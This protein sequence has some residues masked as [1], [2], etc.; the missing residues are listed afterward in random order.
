[1]EATAGITKTAPAVSEGIYD[2]GTADNIHGN[3]EVEA[4]TANSGGGGGSETCENEYDPDE[5]NLYEAV[6]EKAK[7]GV[8]EKATA[9]AKA[10]AEKADAAD[11]ARIAEKKAAEE[12]EAAEVARI[13]AEEAEERRVAEEADKKIR[14]IFRSGPLANKPPALTPEEQEKMFADYRVEMLQ[15]T[16]LVLGDNAEAR[17]EKI[18]DQMDR[19]GKTTT[20]RPWIPF[21]SAEYSAHSKYCNKLDGKDIGHGHDL[22][23]GDW[24]CNNGGH[25]VEWHLL[26]EFFGT[27][28]AG[29][30]KLLDKSVTLGETDLNEWLDV[31]V[32][33]AIQLD[34]EKNLEKL[35]GGR[36]ED[37]KLFNVD[38]GE[39]FIEQTL[40]D[41]LILKVAVKATIN[42][43]DSTRDGQKAPF[44]ITPPSPATETFDFEPVVK[45]NRCNGRVWRKNPVAATIKSLSNSGYMGCQLKLVGVTPCDV[46]WV[47][48][49]PTSLFDKFLLHLDYCLDLVVDWINTG[50]SGKSPFVSQLDAVEERLDK[51]KE[52]SS[53]DEQNTF[54]LYYYIRRLR[55]LIGGGT[56]MSHAKYIAAGKRIYKAGANFR[57]GTVSKVKFTTTKMDG[58][59]G[60]TVAMDVDM[61]QTVGPPV[62]HSHIWP[63][64]DMA[65]PLNES[66]L[67]ELRTSLIKTA[68]AVYDK[69]E[70]SSFRL[71][72]IDGS[73]EPHKLLPLDKSN[74]EAVIN[75]HI[76]AGGIHIDQAEIDARLKRAGAASG[77]ITVSRWPGRPDPTWTSRFSPQTTSL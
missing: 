66:V 8:A 57:N 13:A 46:S 74:Y 12:A 17:I 58:W 52:G 27:D 20:C 63:I 42:P 54:V 18:M 51:E 21:P 22:V 44:V 48:H 15:R 5:D 30:A 24:Q 61:T 19:I 7:A 31:N 25:F 38:G 64:V 71:S 14:G 23:N 32:K 67:K 53:L 73:T 56:P 11:A 6:D 45:E 43:A 37:R 16:G 76:A 69:T 72:K 9:D 47:Y 77:D 33:R 55:S 4:N 10:D 40:L 49:E 28:T 35:G 68:K 41:E 34:H 50:R 60:P 75:E 36:P 70:H 3:D 39:I 29:V 2:D 59:V 65:V 1:M 26:H 62:C